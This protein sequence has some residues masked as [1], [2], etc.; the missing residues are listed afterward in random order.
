[1]HDPNKSQIL[2]KISAR[3]EKP[4]SARAY[5]SVMT[6]YERFEQIVLMISTHEKL[7]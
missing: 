2:L 3:T 4:E 5:W 7:I 6:Y 1:M